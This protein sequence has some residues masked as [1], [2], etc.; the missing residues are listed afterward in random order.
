MVATKA[1]KGLASYQHLW[2]T[3]LGSTIRAYNKAARSGPVD[4]DDALKAGH[5]VEFARGTQFCARAM[6]SVDGRRM[7]SD[8]DFMIFHS[9]QTGFWSCAIPM[10]LSQTQ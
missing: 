7:R 8:D 2:A 3:S 6:Y 10:S 5:C 4:I 1:R 9:A